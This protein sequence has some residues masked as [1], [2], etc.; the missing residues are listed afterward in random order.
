MPTHP[1]YL[2]RYYEIF[3]TLKINKSSL[4]DDDAI[5]LTEVLNS[6]EVKEFINDKYSGSIVPAF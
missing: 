6:E 1:L 5:A 2:W 4:S 3:K